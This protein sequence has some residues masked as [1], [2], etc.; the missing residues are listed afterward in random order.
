MDNEYHQVTQAHKSIL[1]GEPLYLPVPKQFSPIFTHH[2]PYLT[3]HQG[4][5][6]HHG[7]HNH[8]GFM[9][10]ELILT[11]GERYLRRDAFQGDVSWE[12]Y[13]IISMLG[14]N[15][16]SNVNIDNDR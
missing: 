11:N 16:S 10:H 2:P 6:N 4:F 3:R 5:H 12:T 1:P 8:Q 7:I 13:S 15:A 9:A 14:N